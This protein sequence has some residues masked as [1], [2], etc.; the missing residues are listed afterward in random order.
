MKCR[1][2][3]AL[4]IL[5]LLALTALLIR[6]YA[7]TPLISAQTP[8]TPETK[9]NPELARLM[10]EDQADRTPDDAKSIDWKIVGPRDAARLKRVK[11]LYAQNQLKTGG[12]YY[13][14]AMILQHSDV[15][16]D[17]LLAHEL[18]VVAISKGDKRG[19]WLA[20]ASEDRFLMNLNRPQRF[21]TQFRCDG[22]NCEFYLYKVDE[23]VTDELRRVLDVPSLAEAKAREAKMQKKK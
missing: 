19:R 12:D 3:N 8:S 2:I 9:D 23:A 11:E 5:N 18:C 10:A 20:A 16:D 4:L 21:A 22:P 17:F 6:P 14:A 1:T 7:I 13:H 15:A